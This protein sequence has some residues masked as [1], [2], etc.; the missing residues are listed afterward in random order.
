MAKVCC[1]TGR[2]TVSKQP[3]TCNEQNKT[4]ELN[5]IFKKVTIA[6]Y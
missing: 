3:F 5:Q 4:C 6:Y 1:F 2:K